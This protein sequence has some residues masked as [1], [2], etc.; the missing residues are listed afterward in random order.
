MCHIFMRKIVPS[1]FFLLDSPVT[2]LHMI[3]V[4]SNLV[5]S[6]LVEAWDIV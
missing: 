2:A 3:A 6:S 1:K 5:P 4:S